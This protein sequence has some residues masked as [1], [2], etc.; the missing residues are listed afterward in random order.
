LIHNFVHLAPEDQLEYLDDELI[1]QRNNRIV[2]HLTDTE[3]DEDF[4]ILVFKKHAPSPYKDYVHIHPVGSLLQKS[5]PA[6]K[7]LA[8]LEILGRESNILLTMTPKEEA[9]YMTDELRSYLASHKNIVF[10]SKKFSF[11]EISQYIVGAQ[12][13]CTVNTGLLW[14]AVMLSKKTVVCDTHTDHEWNP[15]HYGEVIRLAQDYDER[16]NSLHLKLEI[17]EDGTYFESMYRIK[18]EVVAE[19]L[20]SSRTTIRRMA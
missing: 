14:L 4:P 13:F 17:H 2:A 20:T 5:Y 18:P 3:Y 16:G 7:L 6:K 11:K 12:V 1:W 19:A 9:W 15:V 10:I 8:V